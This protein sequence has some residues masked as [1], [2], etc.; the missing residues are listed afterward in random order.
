MHPN[1]DFRCDDR[2]LLE[3]IVDQVGFG[4]VFASTPDGPRVAHVPIVSTR[5]GAIQF[6][7]ANANGLA[8]HLAGQSALAV[9][10]GPDAYVSARWY[11]DDP[12]QVPTWNYVAVELEGPV[13][14][15]EEE[16]TFAHLQDLIERHEARIE[17][18]ERWH[19]SDADEAYVG[20]L[21]GSITGFEME[22]KAW[23]ETIKLHQDKPAAVREHIADRLDEQ[24]AGAIAH[25]MRTLAAKG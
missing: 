5:D 10:N 4:M 14:R 21:L 8:R 9:I 23:R 22:V 16:G 25:L 15:M 11:G 6:H 24:G 7:L 20:R 2:N 3:E 13:R 19:L 12:K 17:G 1:P 18:G